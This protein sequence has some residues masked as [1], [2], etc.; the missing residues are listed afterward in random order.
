MRHLLRVD[1]EYLIAQREELEQ[2]RAE[3]RAE[4]EK[5]A[6]LFDAAPDPY[7]VTDTDLRVVAANRA[8]AELFNISQRFLSGKP[9][10]VFISRDR[11]RFLANA[12]RLAMAADSALWTFNLRPRERA[13]LNVEARV[14]THV[15]REGLELHWL[16][17]PAVFAAD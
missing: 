16:L 17:R 9:L 2:T 7:V 11:G 3:L 12:A 15:T 14:V 5:Y 13:P 1:Q 4:R 6:Q 8:A 10:S